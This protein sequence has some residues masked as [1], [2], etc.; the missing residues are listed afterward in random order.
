MAGYVP[1]GS[2][3]MRRQ[4]RAWEAAL[5]QSEACAS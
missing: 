3:L 1:H 4:A 2:M 5:E